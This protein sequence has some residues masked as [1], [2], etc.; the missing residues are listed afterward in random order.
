MFIAGSWQ[1]HVMFQRILHTRHVWLA[2]GKPHLNWVVY[3]LTSGG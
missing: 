2:A 3:P 1:D